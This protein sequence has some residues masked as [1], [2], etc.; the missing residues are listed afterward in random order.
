V[1]GSRLGRDVKT[2]RAYLDGSQSENLLTLAAMSASPPT[3]ERFE[4]RWA[5][6]LEKHGVSAAHMRENREPSFV[7]NLET[8]L[9]DFGDQKD[10]FCSVSSVILPHHKVVSQAIDAMEAGGKQRKFPE[11]S[12]LCAYDCLNYLCWHYQTGQFALVFDRNEPFFAK[13]YN[14]WNVRKGKTADHPHLSRVEQMEPGSLDC[15]PPLQAADFIAWHVNRFW[16][17]RDQPNSWSLGSI[18]SISSTLWDQNRLANPFLVK[19]VITSKSP[20]K[21]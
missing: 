7:Q 5:E 21:V 2:V 20:Y 1:S 11:A 3:W 6:V 12:E 4:S 17:K 16:T 18:A 8:V 13:L 10:A 19:G 14:P 9:R 15:H